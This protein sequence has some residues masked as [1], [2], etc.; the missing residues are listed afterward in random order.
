MM[1][2]LQV[3]FARLDMTPPLGVPMS[4]Y[5]PTAEAYDQGGYEAGEGADLEYRLKGRPKPGVD[6]ICIAGFRTAMDEFA[7]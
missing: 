1:S 4:G 7:T 5:F 2:K 6:A 3:G